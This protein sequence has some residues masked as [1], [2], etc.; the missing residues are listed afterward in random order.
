MLRVGEE[1]KQRVEAAQ[2]ET[3]VRQAVKVEPTNIATAQ[4]R[5]VVLLQVSN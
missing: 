4:I 3:R 5:H 1:C 2:T